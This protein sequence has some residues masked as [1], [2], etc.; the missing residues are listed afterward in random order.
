MNFT[1]FSDEIAAPIKGNRTASARAVAWGPHNILAIATKNS[2]QFRQFLAS[3][4]IPRSAFG[5]DMEEKLQEVNEM[6]ITCV[7]W[8]PFFVDEK[9]FSPVLPSTASG[10]LTALCAWKTISS[11]VEVLPVSRATPSLGMLSV[12]QLANW[13]LTILPQF[14]PLQSTPHNKKNSSLPPA[15]SY[16]L[17]DTQW[18]SA[19]ELLLIST[20]GILYVNVAETLLSAKP[21]NNNRTQADHSAGT[22]SVLV[23][24]QHRIAVWPSGFSPSCS[25]IVE[26]SSNSRLLVVS[27]QMQ[28]AGK[29]QSVMLGYDIMLSQNSAV[30]LCRCS[31][32]MNVTARAVTIITR[33]DTIVTSDALFLP[34]AIAA[35][36]IGSDSIHSD[37]KAEEIRKVVEIVAAGPVSTMLIHIS[38]S[39]KYVLLG[40]GDDTAHS[41]VASCV[42]GAA[43]VARFGENLSPLRPSPTAP[44]V[45]LSMQN[46]VVCDDL[47][48]HSQDTNVE[49]IIPLVGS[50]KAFLSPLVVLDTA[51]IALP[52]Q[53]QMCSGNLISASNPRGATASIAVVGVKHISSHY[54]LV[55]SDV[56]T[57][58]GI[59]RTSPTNTVTI[60]SEPIINIYKNTI[61]H[62]RYGLAKAAAPLVCTGGVALH[63]SGS[64]GVML[65]GIT[66]QRK[67][68]TRLVSFTTAQSDVFTSA[69]LQYSHL[70]DLLTRAMGSPIHALNR[71]ATNKEAINI[72]L[73]AAY[74]PHRV[75]PFHTAP[76][77]E[78]N[79][80]CLE[81]RDRCINLLAAPYDLENLEASTLL[82]S[83]AALQSIASHH[84]GIY[85][86]G[87]DLNRVFMRV[88]LCHFIHT[89]FGSVALPLPAH[90]NTGLYSPLMMNRFSEASWDTSLRD[91]AAFIPSTQSVPRQVSMMENL[92][93][94]LLISCVDLHFSQVDAGVLG[95][96]TSPPTWLT[97]RLQFQSELYHRNPI[98][99]R[100]E[101]IPPYWQRL[102]ISCESLLRALESYRTSSPDA[103]AW[104]SS[105][106]MRLASELLVARA[107]CAHKDFSSKSDELSILKASVALAVVEGFVR[108]IPADNDL[109][110]LTSRG[111]EPLL[112][113][114]KAQ[115]IKV[116]IVEPACLRTSG[117]QKRTREQNDDDLSFVAAPLTVKISSAQ[118]G[119]FSTVSVVDVSEFSLLDV[120]STDVARCIG[121]CGQQIKEGATYNLICPLC[122]GQL[123]FV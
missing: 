38:L 13:K 27:G 93:A 113:L 9:V 119:S 20:L 18:A 54:L 22:P 52:A 91:I 99:L 105:R 44:H 33:I 116:R 115:V 19:T 59:L 16:H 10:T 3:E 5:C 71:D 78:V 11:I 30:P 64:L 28:V 7:T 75:T 112:E 31:F 29:Q 34:S 56:I 109:L 58:V 63:P 102:L 62:H 90:G 35:Q 123:T 74:E 79:K 41:A 61:D 67:D 81:L 97:G 95:L 23:D 107:V 51:T 82:H 70:R 39:Q 68:E 21:Q 106:R 46:R 26:L 122:R 43:I 83:S 108:N 14:R 1:S 17:A 77:A 87:A 57:A 101:H 60:Y 12:V 92:A 84:Q 2:V 49:Q 45:P 6:Q 69:A 4:T 88:T 66:R 100:P 86:I 24:A 15:F 80:Q 25:S 37:T 65:C 53:S 118:Q 85:Q 42:L 50:W 55:G 89:I 76:L 96:N 32:A 47:G 8:A 40:T 110:L 73:Q 94:K 117:G 36:I 121:G 120:T 103:M 114:K 104:L 48:E 111:L 72:Q 98:V